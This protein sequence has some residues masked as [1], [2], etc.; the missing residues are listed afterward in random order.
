MLMLAVAAD[1]E[2]KDRRVVE[3]DRR[4]DWDFEAGDMMSMRE[5]ERWSSP[6]APIDH[7]FVLPRLA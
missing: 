1:K 7:K 2:Q 4:V 5:M 3:V 6:D